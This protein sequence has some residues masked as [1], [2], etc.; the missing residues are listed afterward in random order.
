MKLVVSIFA[1]LACLALSSHVSVAQPN[2][3]TAT[4]PPQRI[5][6]TIHVPADGLILDFPIM[7]DETTVVQ[8]TQRLTLGTASAMGIEVE[9]LNNGKRFDIDTIQ[10]KK[11]E[12]AIPIEGTLVLEFPDRTVSLRV[13]E[14][15][16]DEASYGLVIFK[17]EEE[18]LKKQ[19]SVKERALEA[20]NTRERD[21]IRRAKKAEAETREARR[22]IKTAKEET[23][24]WRNAAKAF[25]AKAKESEVRA[26]KLEDQL[27]ENRAKAETDAEAIRRQQL[28]VAGGRLVDPN[29]RKL[30]PTYRQARLKPDSALALS[31]DSATWEQDHYLVALTATGATSTPF[32]LASAQ[33]TDSQAN[34]LPSMVVRPAAP[35]DPSQGIITR[36]Y[37]GQPETIV[38]AIHGAADVPKGGLRLVLSEPS[39]SRTVT[40]AIPRF[41]G[42]GYPETEEQER[43]RL[44]KERNQRWGKQVAL[45]PRMTYGACWLTSGLDNNDELEA[46]GCTSVGAYFV[47]GFH[48]YFA[49]EVEAFGGWTG[50]ARFDDVT[51]GE[52]AGDLTRSAQYGRIALHG[53]ARFSGGKAAPYIRVGAGAQGVSYD[54]EFN[55]GEAPDT[56]LELR[57]FFALGGGINFRVGEHL[58]GGIVA[59]ISSEGTEVRALNAGLH[60]GYSWSP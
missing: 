56:D 12:P 9:E 2:N 17:T 32:R 42:I 6:T 16:A 31:F 22:E 35:V 48:E 59:A 50:T 4:P 44:E 25:E 30:R 39:G 36:I 40:A 29:S 46:V 8:L 53:V 26:A 28:V 51:I 37:Q 5:K 43:R 13:R 19:L 33:V 49:L 27:A 34:P 3:P 20:A 15:G 7:R 24:E 45:G 55:A 21:L 14:A 11:G 57:T 58:V 23:N 54:P 1:A 47:K 41:E 52:A 18:R 38:V 60:L 10:A